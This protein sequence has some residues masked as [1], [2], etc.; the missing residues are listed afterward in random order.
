MLGN[1]R[2]APYRTIIVLGAL[3]LLYFLISTFPRLRKVAPPKEG[4][5]G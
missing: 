1:W 4:E 5:T 3:P 2:V